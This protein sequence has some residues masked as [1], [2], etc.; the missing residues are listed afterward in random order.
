MVPMVFLWFTKHSSDLYIYIYF[1]HF[2]H[3]MWP[4]QRFRPRASDR[5]AADLFTESQDDT[6]SGRKFVA[7]CFLLQDHWMD[8]SQK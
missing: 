1:G 2:G 4:T 7:R 3:E 5:L 8:L 6:T